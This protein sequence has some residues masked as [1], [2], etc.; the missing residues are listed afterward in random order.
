MTSE[1]IQTV[2]ICFM[3]SIFIIKC[4]APKLKYDTII[5]L[6]FLF[7]IAWMVFIMIT[8][9]FVITRS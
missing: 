1:T 9:G 2:W 6:L 7:G 8:T 4:M 3:I 5:C